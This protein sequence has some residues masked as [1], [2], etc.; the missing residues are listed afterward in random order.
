MDSRLWYSTKPPQLW[1]WGRVLKVSWNVVFKTM[2]IN[3][4]LL[5]VCDFVIGTLHLENTDSLNYAYLP[6]ASTFHCQKTIFINITIIGGKKSS[7]TWEAV[8]PMI[9]EVNFPK[10]NFHLKL[11]NSS[12]ETS[13]VSLVFLFFEV[14]DSQSFLTIC[15]SN[16]K[17]E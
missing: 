7:S 8:R 9:V 2:L 16:T 14:T 17:S 11:W 4:D 13:A 3:L 10:F 1:E 15:L 5:P 12:L 6:N